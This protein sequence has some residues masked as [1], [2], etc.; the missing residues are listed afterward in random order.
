MKAVSSSFI[1]VLPEGCSLRD[2][3]S[4]HPE[5]CFEEVGRIAQ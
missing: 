3:L 5:D 1:W 2:S 4:D